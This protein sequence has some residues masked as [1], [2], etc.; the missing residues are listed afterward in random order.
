MGTLVI[1]I[2]IPALFR[3]DFQCE[4]GQQPGFPDALV[5]SS[6]IRDLNPF[7]LGDFCFGPLFD[8]D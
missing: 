3:Y 1:A 6:H 4:N 2:H 8:Q 7:S 5:T